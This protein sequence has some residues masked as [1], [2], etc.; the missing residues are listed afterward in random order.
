M[1]KAIILILLFISC[2]DATKKENKINVSL[3]SPI[4]SLDPAIAY[5]AVSLEVIGQVYESLFEYEYLVRPYTLRPLLAEEMPAISNNG[6]TYTIKI[7]KNIPYHSHPSLK[8]DRFVTAQ[9]FINQFKRVAYP[10]T[11]S[12]GWW[13]FEGKIKG[14]DSFRKTCSDQKFDCI[15]KH[16]IAGIKALDKHTLKIELN[17]PYPQFIYALALPFSSPIPQEIIT[18][19]E[20][21][22]SQ[23]AIGTGPFIFKEWNKN[24]NIRLVKNPNYNNSIFPQKGDRISNDKSLLKDAGKKLPFLDEVEFHIIKEAQ[25]RWLNFLAEKIDFIV[26][27][28]DQFAVALNKDGK[29]KEEYANKKIGL[30]V[31]PTLTYW[32]LSFNMK[33]PIVGKNL[34]LRKAIAHAVDIDK[35]I[36]LY[37]NNIALKANSIFPPG[38]E[39]YNPSNE[40]SFNYNVEKAKE[41]MVK[42]GYPNGEGLPTLRYDVRGNSTV[43]RQMGEFIQAELSRIGINIT[44]I[45]NTFPRFLEKADQGQLQFWQDGWI[46]DYPDAENVL[47][48]LISKNFAP[49]PNST[50]FSDNYIDNLYNRLPSFSPEERKKALQEVENI[51]QSELPWIMEYYSRNYVLYHKKVQNLRQSDLIYSRYKYLRVLDK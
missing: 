48:L 39:G 26:L 10:A 1:I 36:E 7:K 34:N 16:E 49:G 6:M 45:T 33:D 2:N 31:S 47:Q 43:D 18:Y 17:F 3:N 35:Y 42:A 11:K 27:S 8:K 24:L 19:Y 50:F 20:N 44:V 37:T 32:W 22:L 41:F 12:N 13:L 38:I 28:K 40:L 51:V 15:F 9:D 21:D 4:P 14:I 29:L 25:T 5:D 23:F 46:L 30:Q